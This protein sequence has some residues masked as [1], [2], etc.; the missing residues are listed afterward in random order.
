MGTRLVKRIFLSILMASAALSLVGCASPTGP[1]SSS[2]SGSEQ[3]H[4][5]RTLTEFIN[6]IRTDYNY[7]FTDAQFYDRGLADFPGAVATFGSEDPIQGTYNSMP[8]ASYPGVNGRF[9]FGPRDPNRKTTY[10]AFDYTNGSQA[11]GQYQAFWGVKDFFP[12]SSTSVPF[13]RILI[14][15]EGIVLF[16]GDSTQKYRVIQSLYGDLVNEPV[17]WG[18]RRVNPTSVA[19]QGN[20]QAINVQ[21][22]DR[23]DARVPCLFNAC[24]LNYETIWV[25]Q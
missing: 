14:I 17:Q 8:T 13:A 24:G 21:T 23:N 19:I 12:R 22:I 20:Y 1:S 6:Q 15:T 16:E 5:A 4:L 11:Q 10:A 25:R 3:L 18:T 7:T 9:V 2:G